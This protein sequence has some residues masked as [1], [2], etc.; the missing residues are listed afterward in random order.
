V[1][2]GKQPH[3]LNIGFHVSEERDAPVALISGKELPLT[4]QEKFW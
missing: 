1:Y 3:I 2:G 4:S